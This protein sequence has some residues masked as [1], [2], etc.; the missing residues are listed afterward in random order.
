MRFVDDQAMLVKSQ[1]SLN[2]TTAYMEFKIN[3]MET[4]VLKIS[5]LKKLLSENTLKGKK[6]IYIA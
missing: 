2:T 5:K 1:N 6:S 4:K 3:I